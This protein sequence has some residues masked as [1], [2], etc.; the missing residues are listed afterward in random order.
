MPGFLKRVL[1]N[2]R[3][4]PAILIEEGHRRPGW[5]MIVVAITAGSPANANDAKLE[6]GKF[7]P[8]ERLAVRGGPICKV[9]GIRAGEIA[10]LV[11]HMRHDIKPLDAA[12]EPMIELFAICRARLL[13]AEECD[14][15]ANSVFRQVFIQ[16]AYDP[17]QELLTGRA[18]AEVV[19]PRF[20]RGH[21]IEG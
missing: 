21:G 3:A 4:D 10:A 2:G 19:G 14:D 8:Q 17:A 9:V 18:S 13:M 7:R 12:G 15:V 20:H 1:S 11:C 16:T 6:L 5:T